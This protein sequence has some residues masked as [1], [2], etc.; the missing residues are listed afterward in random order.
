VPGRRTRWADDRGETLVEVLVAVVILGIAG[1]AVMAGLTL[2]VKASDIHRKQT[3]GGAY[4]RSYAEAIQ[5]YVASG[6]YINCAAANAYNVNAVTSQITDLPSSFT[7]R[8]TAAKSV[9]TNG[10]AA[11]G[12]SADTGIQQV[13]LSV[14][15]NDDRADETLTVV[16]RKPCAPGQAACT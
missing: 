5:Q 3:T 9:G 7:P 2:S 6:H 8:Q 12:C 1:V 4:V 13:T 11:S 15:S 10:A 14:K 16:L